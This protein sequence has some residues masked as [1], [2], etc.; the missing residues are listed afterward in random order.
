[1]KLSIIV[2]VYNMAS[3]GKL[4]Y[5]LDSLAAQTI[6]DYEVITVDDA[7]TDESFSILLEYEKKYPG[8]FKAVHSEVNKRQGGAKNI[9]LSLAKGEWIGFIDSDDW[10]LPTMYEKLIGRAEETGADMVGCD[11]C[12]TDEHSMKIGK[13]VENGKA[14]Q[15]GVLGNKQCR[16]LILD[17]GS[18][19]VKVYRREIFM[20]SGIRFPEHIFTR[21]M[22]SATRCCYRHIIMNISRRSCIFITSMKR[23]RCIPS[24]G[25]AVKTGW[26]LDGAFWKMRRNS[27]I[28]KPTDR[29]SA[30]NTRCCFMSIRCFP[31][32]SERVI[33][34]FLLSGRWETN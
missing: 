17:S 30:L 29:K 12:L 5:C 15:S 27:V 21:I 26:R 24:A 8:K 23:P 25:S 33:N 11:Y 10:I 16:S 9:G 1:M 13:R 4:N 18:L 6:S 34:R 32:W 14:E 3:D 19:V 7:S 22:R 31:I 2:P 28:L 20:D